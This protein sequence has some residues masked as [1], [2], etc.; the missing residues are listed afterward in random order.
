MLLNYW[1]SFYKASVQNS[2]SIS[3][4]NNKKKKAVH[5]MNFDKIEIRKNIR[6]L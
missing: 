2:I 6:W 3:K 4:E 5:T 1:Q